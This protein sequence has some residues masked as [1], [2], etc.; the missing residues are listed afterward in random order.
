MSHST[1][2]ERY[3]QTFSA[4]KELAQQA[5]QFFPD[6]VT[7]DSRHAYPFPIYIDHAQGSRKWCINGKEFI[8]YWS[9]HGALLLGH[10]P[11]QIVEAVT[12]QI[13][14]GTHPTTPS[15]NHIRS[16]FRD[17]SPNF[18]QTLLPHGWLHRDLRDRESSNATDHSPRL[19]RRAT[20]K[21][22]RVLN[23]RDSCNSRALLR[24][25]R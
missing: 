21:A 19:S 12:C 20:G 9:G 18:A 5:N 23:S 7:H 2:L 13:Q 25:D 24:M 14:R 10:N 1:I 15:T 4:D 3:D 17:G 22:H 11:A 16:D 8:D 6:G